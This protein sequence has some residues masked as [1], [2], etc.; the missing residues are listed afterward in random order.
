MRQERHVRQR[1]A[2]EAKRGMCGKGRAGMAGECLWPEGAC[3]ASGCA[4]YGERA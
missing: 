4:W 3:I 2:C 1:E